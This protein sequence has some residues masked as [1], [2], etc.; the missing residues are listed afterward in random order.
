MQTALD[1]SDTVGT[2]ARINLNIILANIIV[3]LFCIKKRF[4]DKT[5][6]VNA[7][8]CPLFINLKSLN[9]KINYQ[10]TGWLFFACIE[11]A[12]RVEKKAN[13]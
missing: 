10:G 9:N 8:F 1:L 2:D 11:V 5:W 4:K 12:R 13:N 7:G 3:I 6:L